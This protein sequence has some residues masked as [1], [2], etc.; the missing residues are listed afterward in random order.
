MAFASKSHTDVTRKENNAIN[1]IPSV[2][3]QAERR[4]L[5]LQRMLHNISEVHKG[6]VDSNLKFPGIDQSISVSELLREFAGPLADTEKLDTTAKQIA[7][8]NLSRYLDALEN[9]ENPNSILAGM[10]ET[11][12]K[13]ESRFINDKDLKELG[14]NKAF[15]DRL[16]R[17]RK[18][19]KMIGEDLPAAY[20]Y[21]KGAPTKKQLEAEES[22]VKH[23]QEMLLQNDF[24]RMRG[25]LIDLIAARETL[26]YAYSAARKMSSRGE[27]IEAAK[28]MLRSYINE[29]KD[30]AASISQPRANLGTATTDQP[31]LEMPKVTSDIPHDAAALSG[32]GSAG[33][34]LLSAAKKEYH[35][36]INELYGEVSKRVK[37]LENRLNAGI[38]ITDPGMSDAIS[39]ANESNLLLFAVVHTFTDKFKE[40]L[41][42]EELAAIGDLL[43]N[44]NQLFHNLSSSTGGRV[45][46]STI[47]IGNAIRS[48][49]NELHE[50]LIEL[51]GTHSQNGGEPKDAES[52]AYKE[53][54][55]FINGE[56]RSKY[57]ELMQ[58]LEKIGVDTGT[59]MN[60]YVRHVFDISKSLRTA[61]RDNLQ[62][63]GNQVHEENPNVLSTD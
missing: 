54:L 40:A 45:K 22:L 5:E 47:N 10:V 1:S 53:L 51:H 50:K 48:H 58:E 15:R 44:S 34:A 7:A 4:M 42:K 63:S 12:R 3:N 26:A 61:S 39:K 20:A 9:R 16:A 30:N 21:T 56:Y 57:P 27:G 33:V 41:P 37:D 35:E 11:A 2:L 49:S 23:L 18:L 6:S 29:Q 19:E 17:F 38:K 55:A 36:T 46:V 14:E 59:F 13:A 60:E 52:R 8:V 24:V 31:T 32:A 28:E 43:L 25:A 62:A